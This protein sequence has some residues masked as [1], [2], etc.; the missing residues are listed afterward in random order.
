MVLALGEENKTRNYGKRKKQTSQKGPLYRF[1]LIWTR[2]LLG[3]PLA[4]F[5]VARAPRPGL[6]ESQ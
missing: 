2:L 3:V 5:Q 1:D 4:R 6:N